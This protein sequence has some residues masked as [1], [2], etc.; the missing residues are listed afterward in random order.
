LVLVFALLASTRAE[1]AV[2]PMCSSDGRS[3]IAPP[4]MVPNRG[5]V[6]EA[7]HPCPQPER[8]LMRSMPRDPGGQPTPPSDGPI[9][10]LPIVPPD[11]PVPYVGR[12]THHDDAGSMGLELVCSIE[13]P[14]RG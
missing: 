9:R 3:V 13:R 1:A 5:L 8:A 14:P 11:L 7:P 12:R 10:A 6:L 2:V 4:I